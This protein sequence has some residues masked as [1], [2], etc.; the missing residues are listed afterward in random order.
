MRYDFPVLWNQKG[1]AFN[2]LVKAVNIGTVAGEF[3]IE[4]NTKENIEKAGEMAACILCN[5]KEGESIN[6]LRKDAFNN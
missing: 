1:T 4:G 5:T 2:T 3:M 6:T